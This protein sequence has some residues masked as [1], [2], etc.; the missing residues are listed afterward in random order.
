VKNY[1]LPATISNTPEIGRDVEPIF[2]GKAEE[3]LSFVS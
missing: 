2:C 3:K 1:Q